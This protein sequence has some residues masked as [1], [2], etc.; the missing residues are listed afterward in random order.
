MTLSTLM[1]FL[2]C[3]NNGNVVVFIAIRPWCFA[4][5]RPCPPRNRDEN[6]NGSQISRDA[7]E[8]RA[9]A[10]ARI[11]REKNLTIV[12]HYLVGGRDSFLSGDDVNKRKARM[13]IAFTRDDD[14]GETAGR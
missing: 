2:I 1:A 5:A 7:K 13:R 14:R 8:E 4:R 6:D 3:Q 12:R 11:N 9:S 10:R